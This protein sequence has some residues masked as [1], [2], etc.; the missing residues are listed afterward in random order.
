MGLDQYLFAVSMNNPEVVEEIGYWRKHANLQGYMQ[1][2]AV[3]KKVVETVNDFNCIDLELSKNDV[4][5][6]IDAI[7]SNDL[8][9]TSGFFFGESYGDEAEKQ[10]DLVA[11]DDALT[12]CRDGWKVYYRCWW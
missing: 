1:N 4:E 12:F 9:R 5:N 7:V 3:E 8:P 6:V 2:L 11:F 10:Q